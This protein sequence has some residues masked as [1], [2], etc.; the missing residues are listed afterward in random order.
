MISRSLSHTHTASFICSVVRCTFQKPSSTLQF[1]HFLYYFLPHSLF[2]MYIYIYTFVHLI[3]ASKRLI[4]SCWV[5]PVANISS[6]VHYIVCVSYIDLST[7]KIILRLLLLFALFPLPFISV[8][9]Y[10]YIYLYT[11][12][13][14][15]AFCRI[16]CVG[17][18]EGK[19]A[20][21]SVVNAHTSNI[22]W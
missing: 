3:D 13:E 17:S 1:N 9:V 20:F 19:M 15:V 12:Y 4:F 16:W 22:D 11:P 2:Y 7:Y 5:S 21:T 10:T 8:C 18:R 14:N 6:I